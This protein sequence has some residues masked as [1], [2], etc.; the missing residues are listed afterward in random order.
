M[1]KTFKDLGEIYVRLRRCVTTENADQSNMKSNFVSAVEG[2]IPEK[3]LKGRAVT[4]HAKFGAAKP[5]TTTWVTA[6]YPFGLEHAAVYIFKYR[7]HEDL[8]KEGIIERS[9]SLPPLEDR[10]PETLTREEALELLRRSRAEE[11]RQV[12]IKVEGSRRKRARSSTSTATISSEPNTPGDDE[13]DPEVAEGGR[14]GKRVR[15]ATEMEVMTCRPTSLDA[16]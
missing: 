5:H 8:Q 13:D 4:S 3:A 2:G 7:T 9:P 16:V 15:R 11:E 10:D 6:T 12:A 14:D 1:L